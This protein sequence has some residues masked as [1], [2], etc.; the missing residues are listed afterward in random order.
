MKARQFFV[1]SYDISDD[2]RRTRVF[3]TLKNF[4]AHVQFSVFE[5]WLQPSD[6]ANLKNR[7]KKLIGRQDNIRIYAIGQED[8]GRIQV[9]GNK[10]VTADSIFYLH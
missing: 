5:C 2:R 6:L 10:D 9:L 1:V 3:K 7:L 8:V 4:G